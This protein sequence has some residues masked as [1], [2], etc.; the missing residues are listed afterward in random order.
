MAK[1]FVFPGQG[2]QA[3]G[4]GKA[5]AESFAPARNV[6][7]E[8][9]EALHQKLSALMFEGP[10][11]EL[12]LTANA[13]PAL[14]ATSL[15]VLRV[16]EAEAGLDLAKDA[17]FVAGHSLGEYSALAAADSLSVTDAARLLRKRG[18]AMQQA[19]P[20]GIGAMAALIGLDLDG[21]RAVAQAA[22]QETGAVCSVANDNGGG[23]VVISGAKTA[24]DA[25]IEIAKTKG[26]RRAVPLAVSAPFHCPLMQPAADVMAAALSDV[27]IKRPK[28]PLVANVVA[29]PVDEPQDIRQR[30]IEQVTGTVRWRESVVYMAAQGANNFIELGS[31]KVLTGLLK[32][33]VAEAQ[34]IAIGT[35]DEI[36]AYQSI[37]V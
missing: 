27:E 14:M 23:Q 37:S 2:S 35:P 34:G 11:A 17:A 10:E 4:M 31:G 12:T 8:V 5:L 9:D 15:A 21:A 33:I 29:A 20:I 13:Q 3:V 24:V 26:V 36:A 18:E 28:V 1:A 6:F 16:L 25:A 7:A 19:V 30:L 22:A 32:R